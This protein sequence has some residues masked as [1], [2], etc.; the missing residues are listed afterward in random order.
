[1]KYKFRSIIFLIT[2]SLFFNACNK[3]E[4]KKPQ[5]KKIEK[6]QQVEILTLNEKFLP[7]WVSFVGKTQASKNVDVIARVKGRLEKMHFKPGSMVKEGDLLFE[8]EDDEYLATLEQQKA[9]L[10]QDKAN[11]QLSINDIKRY[12]PLV[13]KDLATK[14][15]LDQLIAKKKE[16]EAMVMS[17]KAAIRQAKL[18]LSYCT[19]I[20][21]IS[22]KIGRNLLDVGNMVGTTSDNSK[23]AN[24]VS[25]NPMYIYLH[26]SNNQVQ[27]MLEYQSQKD[28]PVKVYQ[29][30]IKTENG[31]YIYYNGYIDFIDNTTNLTTGTVTI[32]ASVKNNS[33][34]LFPGSFVN[35]D[36]FVTNKI[37]VIA[38]PPTTVYQNQLGSY[39]YVVDENNRIQTRQFKQSFAT[40]NLIAVKSGLK[41]GD[42]I[43]ISGAQ[44]LK[45]DLLVQPKE[46]TKT[47]FKI[48]K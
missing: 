32:R 6:A 2:A 35:V 21:R 28:M 29:P 22:G 44:K 17:D 10:E 11:L 18:N 38:V 3:E 27:K 24:I 14:E 8:I 15:K 42:K 16:V 41:V 7:I 45:K 12:E 31:K 48:N 19:I 37:P 30:D 39:V 33:Y 43:V 46:T 47:L 1:M 34:T 36:V 25:S 4:E 23:L 40:K 20:A 5:A 9:K 26:P 13:A